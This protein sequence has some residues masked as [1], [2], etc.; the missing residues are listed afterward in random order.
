MRLIWRNLRKYF[1]SRMHGLVIRAHSTTYRWTGIKFRKVSE[2]SWEQ[3]HAQRNTINRH[4]C[5]CVHFTWLLFFFC[6]FCKPVFLIHLSCCLSTHWK[7]D[8][9]SSGKEN[10]ILFFFKWARPSN[11]QSSPVNFFFFFFYND[12]YQ[13]LQRE[14]NKA[15]NRR[16]RNGEKVL[17]IL[18]T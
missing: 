12:Q 11:H 17:P 5:Q 1:S 6:R 10:L 9:S 14:H 2:H 8:I 7:Y 4:V 16:F 3:F 18:I 13:L 15:L